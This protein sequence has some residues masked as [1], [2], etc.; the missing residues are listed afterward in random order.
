MSFQDFCTQLEGADGQ[1]VSIN[2]TFVISFSKPRGTTHNIGPEVVV[3]FLGYLLDHH[4]TCRSTI[5]NHPDYNRESYTQYQEKPYRALYQ[6]VEGE[7]ALNTISSLGGSQTLHLTKI[8]TK[9]I[10]YLADIPYTK[11]QESTHFDAAAVRA[12]LDNMPSDLRSLAGSISAVDP[13]ESADIR[14][15]FENWLRKKGLSDKSVK[16]YAGS[17][18]NRADSILY[19]DDAS[20]SIYD[21]RST[22]ELVGI[23]EKLELDPDW[24]QANIDG[25]EMWNTAISHYSTFLKE[26]EGN[27]R[28]PSKIVGALGTPLAKPFLLLAGISGTGKTRFVREQARKYDEGLTNFCLVPVRPDWHE[29]SDLFGYVTRLTGKAQFVPTELVRFIVRAWE[30]VAPNASAAGCGEI[31]RSAVP[32]WLCL[33]E[34]NLAPVEQYFSDYLSVMESRK[35]TTQGFECDALIGRDLLQYLSGEDAGLRK[36]LGVTGDDLWQYFLAN[37]IQLPPNLIV[38]GTVNLDETTHGFSRKVIDRALT[39]DFGEFYPNDYDDFFDPTVHPVTF[40]WSMVTH[41]SKEVLADTWDTGGAKSIAFLEGVNTILRRTP[42][43]LAYRALNELLIQVACINPMNEVELQ[44]VWDDFLMM[45][46]LPRIEGDEEKLRSN[47][48]DSHGTVLDDLDTFLSAQLSVIW[49][50]DRK[51][52][53]RISVLNDGDVKINCRSKAKIQWMRNRLEANTFTSFWP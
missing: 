29:P 20:R 6:L 53:Y 39:F 16:N 10:C 8:I 44:A 42:F 45:K 34:M 40:S 11:V 43:E 12:A 19:E 28:I 30:V 3:D 32:Y 38:A 14:R 7:D 17:A 18:M 24:Q 50:D 2:D 47:S 51:D 22:K 25:K 4:D 41:A 48:T 1:I 33:D 46:I 9:M 36:N 35:Y 27:N 52:F 49:S 13:A 23:I 5:E 37:G 26:L 21:T 31:D 15:L